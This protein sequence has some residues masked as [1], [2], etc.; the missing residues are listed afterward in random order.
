VDPRKRITVE[1]I[2]EHDFF[3]F[4]KG[5]ELPVIQD[6]CHEFTVRRDYLRRK[7]I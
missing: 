5:G 7:K 6:E 1:G 2:L 4:F 3:K